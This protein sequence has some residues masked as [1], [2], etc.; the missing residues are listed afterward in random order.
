[1]TEEYGVEGDTAIVTGSSRGI[2][3]AIAE[4]FAKQ[5]TNVVCC[6]RTYA[7]VESTAEAIATKSPDAEVVPVECDVRDWDAVEALVETT[8]EAFGDVDV[9][10]NNAGT[11]RIAPFEKLDEK[12]WR[13]VVETN[14][15]GTFVCTRVVG[16]RMRTGDGGTIVNISGAASRWGLPK[17]AHYAASKA[18]VESLTRTV[19]YEWASDDVRVNAVAPGPILTERMSEYLGAD[20]VEIDERRVDRHLGKPDEIAR[21]VQFLASPAARFIQGETLFAK[22]P[23]RIPELDLHDEVG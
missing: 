7:D 13:T 2:G 10:V 21:V 5:G 23:P 9:L 6:S 12:T 18:A 20:P 3:R 15:T 1:M 8:V 4:R 17:W 16:E 22:G 19:A 11:N 14:L